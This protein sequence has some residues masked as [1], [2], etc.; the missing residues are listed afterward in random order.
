MNIIIENEPFPHIIIEDYFTEE[1]SNLIW[2]E[3][4]FLY[5]KLG[6]PE[7]FVAAKNEDGSYMT[8]SLGLSL[9]DIY[10]ERKISDILTISNKIFNQEL[11]RKFEL[12]NEYWNVIKLS[13]NDFTKLRFY[14]EASK[15]DSHRDIWVN[16]IV[17]T[18]F[19]ADQFSGGHLYFPYHNFS[20]NSKH[21]KTVIF[22]G[23]VRHGITEIT[24]GYRFAI[25]KFIHCEAKK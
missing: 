24:K 16:A 15:Y 19:A 13:S 1:E 7:D 25:T 9:D 3:I 22:P 10:S 20:I 11:C 12:K 23:W 14:N 21:N 6:S 5:S 17:T 18:T 4:D 2:R 8:N